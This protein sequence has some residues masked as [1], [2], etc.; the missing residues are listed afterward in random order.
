[1]GKQWKH[2]RLYFFFGSKITAD[3]DCSK[4]G[5]DWWWT[6]RPGVL[7]FMGLQRVRHE[8]ATELNWSST[9][10]PFLGFYSKP[11]CTWWC[12]DN[13]NILADI[14]TDPSCNKYLCFKDKVINSVWKRRYRLDFCV[15]NIPQRRNGNPLQYYCLETL[16]DRGT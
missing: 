10:R 4:I 8:W 11:S 12:W 9:M 2:V 6:G 15:R 14:P 16:M 1:M 3:G 13:E 7:R 5:V